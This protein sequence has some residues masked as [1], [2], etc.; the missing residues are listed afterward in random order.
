LVNSNIDKGYKIVGAEAGST[1]G[2][3]IVGRWKDPRKKGRFPDDVEFVHG[4]GVFMKELR[5]EL[6][7]YS[8]KVRWIGL[9]GKT[10]KRINP[11]FI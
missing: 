1:Y 11:G 6:D 8:I 3:S 7:K 2:I 4:M 9:P 10:L 5:E